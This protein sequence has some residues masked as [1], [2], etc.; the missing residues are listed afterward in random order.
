MRIIIAFL[1][2]PPVVRHILEHIGEP[3]TPP[4]VLPARGPPQW[5]EGVESSDKEPGFDP[6][7]EY[8]Y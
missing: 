8:E 4:R 6:A 7:P 3:S 2:A 1:T 5:E